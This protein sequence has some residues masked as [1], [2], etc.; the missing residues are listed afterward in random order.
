MANHRQAAGD[1]WEQDAS[2]GRVR[3]V[4]VEAIENMKF[5][6]QHHMGEW[7]EPIPGKMYPRELGGMDKSVHELS[8]LLGVTPPYIRQFHDDGCMREVTDENGESVDGHDGELG[9]EMYEEYED[10][11]TPGGD[12]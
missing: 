7:D 11:R 3:G 9:C 4:V 12:D 8:E 6:I 5:M 10:D 1:V 2:E